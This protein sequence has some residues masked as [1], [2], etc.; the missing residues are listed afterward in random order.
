M[1]YAVKVLQKK[2]I[3]KNKEVPEL[4]HKHFL[5]YSSTPRLGG[6]PQMGPNCEG[7]MGWVQRGSEQGASWCQDAYHSRGRQANHVSHRLQE[8]PVPALCLPPM[9]SG[10][11]SGQ[12]FA[13]PGC[14]PPHLCRVGSHLLLFKGPPSHSHPG[15]PDAL[16]IQVSLLVTP[17]P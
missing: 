15:V 4:R 3:L 10:P 13:L 9:K 8:E 16:L 11:H 1:F 5:S 12:S 6:L 2:F 14:P 7:S 17:T